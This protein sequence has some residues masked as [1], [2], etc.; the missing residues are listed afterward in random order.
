MTLWRSIMLND[1]AQCL[2]QAPFS[3]N[4]SWDSNCCFSV[5]RLFKPLHFNY[6][7]SSSISQ[8]FLTSIKTRQRHAQF[9]G[10]WSEI[11]AAF[12][13]AYPLLKIKE[14]KAK[15][16]VRNFRLSRSGLHK[17][18]VVSQNSHLTAWWVLLL[19]LLCIR[20]TACFSGHSAGLAVL[21]QRLDEMG[22]EDKKKKLFLTQHQVDAW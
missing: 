14:R 19:R 21:Q 16:P 6:K 13:R 20:L 4:L 11:F 10:Y 15:S 1:F 7:L 12:P 2:T 9:Y 22:D 17:I 3:W 8:P 18:G 5:V